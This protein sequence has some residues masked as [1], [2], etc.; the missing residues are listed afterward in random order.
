M[1]KH[2]AYTPLKVQDKLKKD[3]RLK[4]QYAPLAVCKDYKLLKSIQESQQ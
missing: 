2:L 3:T 1:V 4:V